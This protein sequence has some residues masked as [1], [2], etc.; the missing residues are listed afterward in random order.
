MESLYD[1]DL[2]DNRDSRQAI[3]QCSSPE[4][5]SIL[6]VPQIWFLLCG[7]GKPNRL[8]NGVEN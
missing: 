1:Y 5:D 6:Y 4:Q 7:P 3:L 2:M 8:N